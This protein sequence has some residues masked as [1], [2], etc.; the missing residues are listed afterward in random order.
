M[1]A[2]PNAQHLARRLDRTASRLIGIIAEQAQ[3]QA[4][5]LYLVGG[6]PR[7]LWLGRGSLDLDF[8]LEGDA[9]AF[10]GHLAAVFGGT[11][12]S[13]PPFGTA[14]W[15]FD[16]QAAARLSLPNLPARIDHID[17]AAARSEIYEQPAALPTVSPGSIQQDM[18][19]RDFSINALALQLSP[20]EK[21]WRILDWQ[22]GIR[23]LQRRQIR[24]LHRR[25]FVDDPTRILRALRFAARLNFCIEP[26]TAALLRAGLPLLKRTSGERLQNEIALILAEEQPERA[27]QKLQAHG[28]LASIHPAWHSS[29][30]LSALFEDSRRQRLDWA[31]PPPESSQLGWVLMLTGIAAADAAAIAERLALPQALAR[32]LTASAQL[33]DHA[34]ALKDPALRPSQITQLL[35]DAPPLALC[36]GW[37]ALMDAPLA[38]QRIETFARHWQKQRATLDGNDLQ[39]MGL[40]PGPR[41]KTLLDRLRFAWLDGEVTSPAEERALLERLLA[42]GD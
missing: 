30:Q 5:S 33:L 38:R 8:A 32:A 31:A 6:L 10:A 17:F 11:V 41:Y 3:Q 26:Q 21:M 22:G 20:A 13:H 16:S 42:G 7:D 14:K 4:Q 29:R 36:A 24:V 12:Q 23:D 40:P 39:R 2:P 15:T 9:I 19:R 1:P 27:L 25:S 34:A 18:Q 35:D 28:V 37:L